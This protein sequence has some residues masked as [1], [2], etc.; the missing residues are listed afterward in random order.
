[1][2]TITGNA[3]EGCLEL[4][5]TDTTG[6]YNALSNPDG[7]GPENTVEGPDDFSTYSLQVWQPGLTTRDAPTY[8][9]NL[10]T[11][12]PL[13]DED[14]YFTWTITAED[15]G[16]DAITSGV[17]TFA[18]TGVLSPNTYV[19]EV[20]K[21]FTLDVK[22]KVIDPAMLNADPSCACE[23]C[24]ADPYTLYAMYDSVACNGICSPEASQEVINYLYTQKGCC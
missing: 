3:C 16:L 23:D 4:T 1:M 22:E 24:D 19:A 12:V 8:T 21:I 15:M 9:L 11:S 20:R 6:A 5:Y 10:L 14:Y 2:L 18:A 13:P 7:Y 17:W